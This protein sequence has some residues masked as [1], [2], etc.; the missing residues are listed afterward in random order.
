MAEI[1]DHCL[2]FLERVTIFLPLWKQD[3][4]LQ[5][6]WKKHIS[7]C[8]WLL[9]ICGTWYLLTTISENS[10]RIQK[11][12]LCY[13]LSS[14]SRLQLRMIFTNLLILLFINHFVNDMSENSE[15]YPLKSPTVQG[16][17]FK[18]LVLCDHRSKTQRYTSSYK[19]TKSKNSLLW[20]W[21]LVMFCII[22]W[23]WQ[24]MNH[25]KINWS[26]IM[27]ARIFWAADML[28]L[29]TMLKKCTSLE[30]DINIQTNLI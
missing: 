30:F 11:W 19:T 8:R 15:N 25:Q 23:K 18:F 1:I 16:G 3:F 5:D 12:C 27:S 14:R 4:S 22:V 7:I 2:L 26:W 13:S 29:S 28:Y 20:N 9:N 24:R 6:M 10:N 17:I 21:E